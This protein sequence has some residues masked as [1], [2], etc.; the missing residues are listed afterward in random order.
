MPRVA[1]RRDLCYLPHRKARVCERADLWHRAMAQQTPLSN[2]SW[3]VKAGG[4]VIEKRAKRGASAL[5]VRESLLYWFWWA[6]YMMR[7]AGDF[8]NAVALEKDFQQE[9]VSLAR[10]LGFRYTDETFSLPRSE[11][12]SQYF[13]RFERVCDELRKAQAE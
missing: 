4:D 11:L 1:V 6:D 5:S 12:K 10:E 13:D 9:I 8:A 2:E 7:N 3:V